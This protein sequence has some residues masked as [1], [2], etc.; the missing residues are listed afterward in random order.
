MWG[1]YKVYKRYKKT[2]D[3]EDNEPPLDEE[4]PDQPLFI[5][6][7]SLLDFARQYG[8]M[9]VA[10]FTN[11]KTEE[12]FK[13]CVFTKDGSDTKVYFF[14]QL[15]VLT[16][17]EISQRQREL[18]IGKTAN[19]KLYLHNGNVRKWQDVDLDLE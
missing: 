17:T 5:E 6:N 12:P 7:W 1:G 9:R 10:K 2:P 13:I 15:G 8:K 3:K 16:P 4:I 14:S 11:S 18:Q 19:G